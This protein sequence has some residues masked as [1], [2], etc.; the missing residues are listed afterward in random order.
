MAKNQSTRKLSV[1]ANQLD[2]ELTERAEDPIIVSPIA[3]EH[4]RIGHEPATPKDSRHT[5]ESCPTAAV[6]G[7]LATPLA[8]TANRIVTEQRFLSG[9]MPF[10][11]FLQVTTG[12]PA[13]LIPWEVHWQQAAAI[14][15]ALVTA[16]AGIVDNAPTRPLPPEFDALLA[17]VRADSVFQQT[18]ANTAYDFRLINVEECVTYQK[19]LDFD[20]VERREGLL[21]RE[22]T[23]KDLI[24]FCFPL[25][26]Q[27]E[28]PQVYRAGNSMY[29]ISESNDLRIN[30]AGPQLVALE[31]DQLNLLSSGQPVPR[32]IA[33]GI[34]LVLLF[35]YS[36][37]FFH[38]LSVEGR[39]VLINGYHRG[40]SL[41]RR[42]QSWL[43]CLVQTVSRDQLPV[44]AA[45]TPLAQTPDLFLKVPRPSLFKDFFDPRL[46]VKLANRPTR[47]MFR[48]SARFEIE[49]GISIH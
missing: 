43:P 14:R 37:N 48:V 21:P 15:Q 10:E 4:Q 49:A 33:K 12:Q 34:S 35:N 6:A 22:L 8:H 30:P 38:V 29:L 28:D 46:Y 45:G 31:P 7:A 1:K 17:P 16:D 19:H 23:P 9:L 44:V 36:L 27:T 39:L 2:A 42:G 13:P 41:I 20:D 47:S 25:E 11:E 26:K 24:A 3:A 40:A 5:M 32:T 18:V